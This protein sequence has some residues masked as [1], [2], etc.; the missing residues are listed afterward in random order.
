MTVDTDEARSERFRTM[1]ERG[2][3][4]PL[5]PPEGETTL[6]GLLER[7]GA[8]IRTKEFEQGLLD[9]IRRTEAE[10]DE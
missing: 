10:D 7:L 5:Q 1:A 8:Y 9:Y 2:F 4:A 6:S 3:S